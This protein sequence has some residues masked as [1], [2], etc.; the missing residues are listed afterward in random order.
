[1]D[2][3]ECYFFVTFTRKLLR[4]GQGLTYILFGMIMA[5]FYMNKGRENIIIFD[6]KIIVLCISGSKISSK[7]IFFFCPNSC[8][9]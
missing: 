4:K 6:E 3:C 5:A 8:K 2:G 9:D 1:M 7:T